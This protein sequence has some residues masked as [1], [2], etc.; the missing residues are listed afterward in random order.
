MTVSAIMLD[1]FPPR[2]WPMVNSAFSIGEV[3]RLM[4]V[5]NGEHDLRSDDDGVY[6][7]L[8]LRDRAAAPLHQQL[9]VVGLR[10]MDIPV[11]THTESEE[12]AK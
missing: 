6:S 5:S 1:L 2:I 11:E 7:C 12:N 8:R 4:S 10:A 3:M 9:K